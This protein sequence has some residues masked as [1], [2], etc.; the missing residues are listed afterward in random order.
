LYVAGE[1]QRAGGQPRS[2]LAE[3]DIA[4][5]VTAW[6][7]QAH[8][9]GLATLY[10]TTG[11]VM[12]GGASAVAGG[13]APDRLA[14]FSLA[15]DD[16]LP[17]APVNPHQV[18]ELA[19]DG[20]R[21][22]VMRLQV[23]D[24]ILRPVAVA[25]ESSGTE[26]GWT[27]HP[28]AVRLLGAFDGHVYLNIWGNTP[29]SAPAAVRVDAITGT[30]DPAWRLDIGVNRLLPSGER[31]YLIDPSS[32][33]HNELREHLAVPDR[34]TGAVG[35]WNPTVLP[36]A[37]G[38]PTLVLDAALD[39]QTMFVAH[40][41]S[42]TR[43][44]G[45]MGIDTDSAVAVA[46]FPPLPFSA[47]RLATADGLLV[48]IGIPAA[49]GAPA[50]ASFR[51]DGSSSTWNPGL[52]L[53]DVDALEP[54]YTEWRRPSVLAT[55]T[56]LVV[57]GIQALDGAAPVHGIAVFARNGP[58]A[59]SALDA[60]VAE[61]AVRLTWTP[62]VPSPASYVLEA[63]SAPGARDLLVQDTGSATPVL[64]AVA[65][66][67]T[68]FVRVRAAG[69]PPGS[70]EAVPS[71]EIAVRVGCSAPPAPPLDLSAT[72]SATTVT[73]QWAA[74][75]LTSVSRYVIEAGSAP[76]LANLARLVVPASGT[77]FT[78]TPPPG[79]SHV[80]VRAENACGRSRPTPD[81][82]LVV[83]DGDL[84]A[85]PASLTVTE[86]TPGLPVGTPR[87]YRVDWSPVPGATAYL[88]EAG[89]RPGLADL[90][91]VI[92]PGTSLGPAGAAWG[93][94][95]FVRVRAINDAGVGPPS[96]EFVV[97]VR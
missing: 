63:G 58:A 46:T 49:R 56:D 19:T 12:A 13:V 20:A 79:T 91:S 47:E 29:D 35:P 15:T 62:P 17:W 32:N 8:A 44:H 73:P 59:P 89:S 68:Y 27:G 64:D 95:H 6:T 96:A 18:V 77:T 76:G 37:A 23:R 16:V 28:D 92:L 2:P 42:I 52:V 24:G 51:T 85:A 81:I 84:P 94:S 93:W 43:A 3:I 55:P 36:T 72:L 67:G 33:V 88:L 57:T 82:W 60:E 66:F 31:V 40:R 30:P 48:A 9:T 21:V 5:A 54:G 65:P 41:H 69:A 97:I 25:F 74:P 80:R 14:A 11:A 39:G 78:T 86:L 87:Q 34:T 4:G 61:H 71:N 70:P 90:A 26:S 7:P 38:G 83:S 22:F 53:S 75:A 10:V 45:I 1:F 50:V